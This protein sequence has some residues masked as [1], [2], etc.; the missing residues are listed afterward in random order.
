[1]LDDDYVH[2]QQANS[3]WPKLFETYFLSP[4][5]RLSETITNTTSDDDL[6]FYVTRQMDNDF[7]HP[8]VCLKSIRLQN[9]ITFFVFLASCRSCSLS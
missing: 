3:Q 7:H 8:L 5:T 4:T 2:I 6:L 9:K 1:M